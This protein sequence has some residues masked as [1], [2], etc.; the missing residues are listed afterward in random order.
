ME[1]SDQ[2]FQFHIDA[3]EEVHETD[4][5]YYFEMLSSAMFSDKTSPIDLQVV[6]DLEGRK[7]A[8]IQT[9]GA[10]GMSS[11][12]KQEAYDLLML[13]LNDRSQKY[14]R[15]HSEDSMILPQIY[16]YF[17]YAFVPVQESAFDAWMHYPPDEELEKMLQSFRELEGAYFLTRAE[18]EL[19]EGVYEIDSQSTYPDYNWNSDLSKLADSAWNTYKMMVSE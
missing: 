6:P 5:W 15:E 1:F 14:T 17:D 11:D 2:Y 16:G 7:M 19:Y 13:F 12:L 3:G 10:V 4:N 8:A 18:R 9:Y